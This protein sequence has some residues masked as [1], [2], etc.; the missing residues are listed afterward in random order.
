MGTIK[1]LLPTR[2]KSTAGRNW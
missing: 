2:G 1:L